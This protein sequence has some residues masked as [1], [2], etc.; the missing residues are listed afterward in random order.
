MPM[1]VNAVKNQSFT[2]P[3]KVNNVLTGIA[4]GT[5][6]ENFQLC[7]AD[8]IRLMDTSTALMTW[9]VVVFSAAIGFGISILPKLSSQLLG[10]GEKVS[11]YEWIALI[12]SILTSL[13]LFGIGKFIPNKKT[14]LIKE[15]KDHFE[16]APRTRQLVKGQK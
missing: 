16:S 3:L 4:L 5:F 12:I 2:K 8:Y 15:M 13:L 10:G 14:K 11:G 1:V 9:A 6:Q 7:E